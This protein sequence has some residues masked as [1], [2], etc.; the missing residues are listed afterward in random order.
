MLP[1]LAI[2]RRP[3][4]TGSLRKRPARWFLRIACFLATGTTGAAA[5]TDAINLLDHFAKALRGLL[6]PLRKAV[7]HR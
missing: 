6:A 3:V 1:G 7:G 2:L 4:C 5:V